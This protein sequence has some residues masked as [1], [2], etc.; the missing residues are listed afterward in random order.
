MAGRSSVHA[1]AGGAQVSVSGMAEVWLAG[2]NNKVDGSGA[3]DLTIHAGAGNDLYIAP[4]AGAGI[5]HIFGFNMAGGDRLQFHGV[6][7][8]AISCHADGGSL[9]VL[10][11][12]TVVAEL[13][14]LGGFNAQSLLDHHSLVFA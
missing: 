10:V 4:A 14:G 8:A 2:W 12:G 3:T 1:G 13:V 5:E 9:D 7:Q 11:N 6:T